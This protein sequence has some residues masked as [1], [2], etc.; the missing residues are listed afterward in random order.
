MGGM[1]AHSC[2]STTSVPAPRRG[3]SRR[4]LPVPDTS[5]RWPRRDATGASGSGSCQRIGKPLPSRT[6]ALTGVRPVGHC[7]IDR[8]DVYGWLRPA[9]FRLPAD[10]AHDLAHL[11]LR[12]PLPFRLLGPSARAGDRRLATDLAGIPLANPVGLAPGFDKNGDLLPSLQHLGFGYIV[13]GSLTPEPRAGNPRPRLV[14][15]PDRLSIANSMGLPNQGGDAAGRRLR[16]RPIT[17]TAGIAS[18]AG[19]SAERILRGGGRPR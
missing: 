13:I 18:R 19:V 14:R 15:Y 4:S 17:P 1:G 16:S 3:R 7:E 6:R 2:A 11:A 10:R 5:E 12:L 9:L 8:M